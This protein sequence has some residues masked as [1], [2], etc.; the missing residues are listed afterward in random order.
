VVVA[1]IAKPEDEDPFNAKYKPT[2]E[3]VD[4]LRPKN[5]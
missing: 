1:C 2:K 4:R 5:D 3:Q